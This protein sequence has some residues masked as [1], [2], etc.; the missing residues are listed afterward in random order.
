[1]LYPQKILDDFGTDRV[2]FGTDA[3]ILEGEVSSSE[4]L[5]IIKNLPRRASP[6]QR[7]TEEEVQ[8]MLEGNARRLLDTIPDR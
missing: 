5:E 8:A 6:A 3:P 1:M 7:F 2:I 4:W